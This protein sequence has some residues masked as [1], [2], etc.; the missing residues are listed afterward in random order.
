R[1][2]GNS[3]AKVRRPPTSH[4]RS[5]ESLRRENDQ[6]STRSAVGKARRGRGGAASRLPCSQERS[7]DRGGPPEGAAARKDELARLTHEPYEMLS[8]RQH[9]TR[10]R[11]LVEQRARAFACTLEAERVDRARALVR[12]VQARRLA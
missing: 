8:L 9:R 6:G 7:G 2:L 5:P 1:W 4:A 3:E 10:A 12:R 11:R